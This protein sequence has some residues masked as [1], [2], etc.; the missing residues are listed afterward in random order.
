ML[1]V[2]TPLSIIDCMEYILPHVVILLDRYVLRALN[3]DSRS[4]DMVLGGSGE[5]LVMA[6]QSLSAFVGTIR[7]QTYA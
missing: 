7:G 1:V 4:G 3:D 2:I 6:F 5:V